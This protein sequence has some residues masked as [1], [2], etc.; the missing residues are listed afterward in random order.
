ME[1]RDEQVRS[2]ATWAVAE[3][4]PANRLPHGR[5]RSGHLTNAED[6]LAVAY[7]L[8]AAHPSR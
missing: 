6:A 4:A 5:V 3:P 7:E 1:E 8:L 2:L